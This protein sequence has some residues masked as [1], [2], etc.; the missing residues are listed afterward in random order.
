MSRNAI[1][2]IE[3]ILG[4]LVKIGQER[5]RLHPSATRGHQELLREEHRL[6]SR[7]TELQDRVSGKKS[8]SAEERA[9]AQTDLTRTPRLPESRGSR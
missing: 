9:A 7:L 5:A 6:Q 8:R 3:R 2:E 1:P 4:R